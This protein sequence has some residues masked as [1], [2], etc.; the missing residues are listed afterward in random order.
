MNYTKKYNSHTFLTNMSFFLLNIVDW[1]FLNTINI[2]LNIQLIELV[3]N[4]FNFKLM[5]NVYND[6][7]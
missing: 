6:D 4:N 2:N 1:A 7:L 3:I 5:K